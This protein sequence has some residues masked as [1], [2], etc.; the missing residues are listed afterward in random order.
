MSDKNNEQIQTGLGQTDYLLPT[1][2]EELEIRSALTRRNLS[3]PDV[4]AAWEQ[5]QT[6]MSA[7]SLSDEQ[8]ETARVYSLSALR[9]WVVYGAAA[10]AVIALLVFWFK[11]ENKQESTRP[12]ITLLA[13]T[14]DKSDVTMTLAQGEWDGKRTDKTEERV[15]SSQSISFEE[16]VTDNS[17]LPKVILMTTPRGKDCHL[18]LSDGT[19]VW[20]NAD[21]KLEF[22]EHFSGSRRTVRLS[23]EAYFEVAKDQR[24]PFV[25]ESSYF[26]TTVVGTTFNMRAY[27]PTDASIA[28]VEGRVSVKPSKGKTIMMNP[29]QLATLSDKGVFSVSKVDTYSY[30]QRKDGFFYFPDDT[31]REIMVELGRWY[32]KTVVFEDANDMNMRLHFVAERTESLPQ[33]INSLSEMDGVEIELGASEIIIK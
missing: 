11:P 9:K 2:A 3:A 23:G 22:P 25:V 20:M 17:E 30:T 7:L 19:Q 8:G 32:N 28:L 15:V 13:Q 6:S 31:M 1:E 5:M 18:T 14:E 4:D 10:I 16:P 29:G 27:S 33:I 12:G 26:T 21:S 24:H